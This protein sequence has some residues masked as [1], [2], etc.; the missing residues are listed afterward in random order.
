MNVLVNANADVN[1]PD[2]EG[3]TAAHIAVAKGLR[4][5]LDLLVRSGAKSKSKGM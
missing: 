1:I 4:Q 2:A 5:A 3:R